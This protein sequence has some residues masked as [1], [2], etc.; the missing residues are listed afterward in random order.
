[1]NKANTWGENGP[2]PRPVVCTWNLS[3]L[4]LYGN[5]TTFSFDLVQGDDPILIGLDESEF[6]NIMNL[7]HETCDIIKRP[8]DNK[9]RMFNTYITRKPD[10]SENRRQNLAIIP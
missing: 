2:D 5:T 1:M 8:S 7:M 9:L 6:S 4:D 10:R 3:T